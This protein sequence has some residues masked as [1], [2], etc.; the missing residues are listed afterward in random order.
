VILSVKVFVVIVFFMMAR[1]SWPRFRF[2]QLMAM[3]WKVMLPLGLVNLI[4]VAFVTEFAWDPKNHR[5]GGSPLVSIAA[6]WGVAIASWWLA[7][8]TAPLATDNRPRMPVPL[9]EIE[10]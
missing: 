6:M 10:T 4:A 9:E 5:L 3:A 1:W 7:G 8:V 2:D